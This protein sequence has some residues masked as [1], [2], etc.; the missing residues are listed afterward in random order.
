[1]PQAVWSDPTVL[2]CGRHLVDP[3]GPP[4]QMPLARGWLLSM[5]TF[6]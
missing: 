2:E 4:D 3:V 6:R 1:M 5:L